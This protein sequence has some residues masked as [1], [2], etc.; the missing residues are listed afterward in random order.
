MSFEVVLFKTTCEVHQHVHYCS[1]NYFGSQQEKDDV[2]QF[3]TTQWD[4]C[5]AVYMI[6]E[7]V[8]KL[9]NLWYLKWPKPLISIYTDLYNMFR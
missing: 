6:E 5:D 2:E 7:Y 1:E 4:S 8:F 3:W 9:S